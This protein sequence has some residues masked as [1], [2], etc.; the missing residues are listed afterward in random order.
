V[1]AVR[2]RAPRWLLRRRSG[3]TPMPEATPTGIL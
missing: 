2:L 1:L 3:T